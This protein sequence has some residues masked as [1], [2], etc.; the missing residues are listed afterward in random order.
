MVHITAIL[1][2]FFAFIF[3]AEPVFAAGA[4]DIVINEVY[5]D[6]DDTHGKET[7]N[8]WVELYNKT[9]SPVDLSSWTI[10]DN[11]STKTIP[12]S[13][14]PVPSNGLVLITPDSSTW[15]FWDIDPQVIKVFMPIGNGLS[16]T[17]DRLILKDTGGSLIDQL[18]Y[19]T[20]IDVWNPALPRIA[21]GHSLER[22]P[23]G[24]DNDVLVDFVDQE[25]PTPGR[26]IAEY[27]PP[28]QNPSPTPAKSPN[29]TST[30]LKSPSPSPTALPKSPSPSPLKSPTPETSVLGESS[31]SATPSASPSP[32]IS[33]QQNP[34]DAIKNNP[35]TALILVGSGLILIGLSSAFYLWYSKFLG[36]SQVKEKEENEDD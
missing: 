18:S 35:K 20:N 6:V 14:S 32:L 12:A 13:T 11:N 28:A 24:V 7:T 17:G 9:G 29:P 15:N 34:L 23:G 3:F 5:Y 31:Q 21:E 22:Y 33:K 25:T 26:L 30:P 8:E 27:I 10:T 1:F 16:N 36:K 19:G 4:S 2:A